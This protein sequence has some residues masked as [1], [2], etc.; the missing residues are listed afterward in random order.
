VKCGLGRDASPASTAVVPPSARAIGAAPRQWSWLALRLGSA[1][2]QA[3][4]RPLALGAASI[5][6]VIEVKLERDDPFCTSRVPFLPLIARV[7]PFPSINRAAR[8]LPSHLH[9]SSGLAAP[10]AGYRERG[11]EVGRCGPRRSSARPGPRRWVRTVKSGRGPATQ[12]AR[13]TRLQRGSSPLNV[14]FP[15][16][17]NSSSQVFPLI[18]GCRD[19]P[20]RHS[21]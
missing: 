21:A 6:S 5:S 12:R 10:C 2:C 16:A 4:V 11:T 15:P 9:P 7:P 14:T 20:P 13:R 18:T 3:R 19:W 8:S 1:P 17:L